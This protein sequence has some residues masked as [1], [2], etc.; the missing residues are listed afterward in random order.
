MIY[1]SSIRD[2]PCFNKVYF[3]I[4]SMGS[5]MDYTD[6]LR[7]FSFDSASGLG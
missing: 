4:G 3:E 1:R 5:E 6:D 2:Q 7:L